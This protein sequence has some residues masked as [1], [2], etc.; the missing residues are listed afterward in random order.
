MELRANS[1]HH[2]RGLELA[3]TGKYQEA[4]ACIQEHLC[5]APDDAQALNDAGT[6]L[7][8]LGRPDEA[9]DHFVKARSLQSDSA[10]I[11]WNLV[12]AYLGVGRVNEAVQLF[13]N[14]ERIGILNADVL[15][16]TANA[17]LAQDNKA[18]AIEMLHHSL[19]LSPGQK[20][21]EPMI[22][23]IRSKMPKVAF[24]CGDGMRFLNETVDFIKQGFEVRLFKDQAEEELYDLMK[25]SDISWF[26]PG[27]LAVTASKLPKLCENII[28]LDR[29][30]A[31]KQWPQQVNWANV[32]ILVTV[33][34]SFVGDALVQK[35]P[36]LESQTS[37]VTVPSGVNLEKFS[38][39]NRRRGKN[40]AFLANLRML[41]N[42]A[43]VLQCMQKLHYIDPE[44]RLFF[45][46]EFADAA[47]EH[48]LKHMVDVLGLRSVVSFD[49]W[50]DDVRCWLEDKHYIVSTSIV[51]SQSM[52]VLEG[53]ACGLKPVVHNFQGAD[54][55][56]PSEFL[57][58]ISEE[59]CEQILSDNYEPQRYRRFVEENY[60]LENQLVK[61]NDIFMRLES[62][63]ITPLLSAE[64]HPAD[65]ESKKG[66]AGSRIAEYRIP[67]TSGL[68]QITDRE[69]ITKG[70]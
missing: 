60:P 13:D 67:I 50:Q 31:Y 38:F 51:E 64:R 42:P 32:D 19:E 25:W 24:F 4:L 26:E 55:V 46:G 36:G 49:G 47:L 35:V 23:V 41:K 3:E 61:I 56:F 12:E 16:R 40:I 68:S 14:M 2:Q 43:F 7:Y 33:G 17:F 45:G 27:H 48:Y 11:L 37:I 6:I 54:Q 66:G 5:E 44:Y 9:I 20:I 18:G 39:T 53:M 8:C 58:N 30:D 69:A 59:F 10:D 22:D 34:N 29:Y 63:S 21:L 52:G 57:F 15:N 70:F 1:N 62:E 28:R 65:C